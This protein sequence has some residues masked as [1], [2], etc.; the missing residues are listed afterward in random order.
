METL[1]LVEVAVVKSVVERGEGVLDVLEVHDPAAALP[2][3]SCHVDL[4]AVGVPVQ[5]GALMVGWDVRE[6]VCCLERELF[7]D[8]HH[9]IPRYL[10]VWRLSRHRGCAMQY[11]TAR[12]VFLSRSGPSMGCSSKRGKSRFSTVAGS[13]P[14][15]G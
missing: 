13:S 10:C 2:D 9:A 6:S 8:L 15:W 14:G 11:S 3:F 4:H 12:R 1:Y 7:E 5:A